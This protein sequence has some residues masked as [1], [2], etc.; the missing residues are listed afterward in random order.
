MK[1]FI[2]YLEE[3]KNLRNSNEYISEGKVTDFV[4]KSA[5][6]A[7]VYLAI[8]FGYK[9]YVVKKAEDILSLPKKEQIEEI[10]KMKNYIETRKGFPLKG[11]RSVESHYTQILKEIDSKLKTN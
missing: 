3:A 4:F 2:N 11:E 8:G 9:S 7:L 5:M 1:N 10:N 6:I